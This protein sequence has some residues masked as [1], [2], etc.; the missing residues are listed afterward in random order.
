M[1]HRANVNFTN[2]FDG[3]KDLGDN[4]NLFLNAN[5]QLLL[6]ELNAPISKSFAQ[7]FKDA[8]NSFFEKTPY[9]NLFLK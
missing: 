4:M 7:V 1:I 8:A 2:L 9:D 3:Q 5:W 6:D